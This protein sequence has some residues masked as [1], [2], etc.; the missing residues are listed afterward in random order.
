MNCLTRFPHL[1]VYFL[2][3]FNTSAVAFFVPALVQVVSPISS[4]SP[5]PSL[6]FAIGPHSCS[7]SDEAKIKVPHWSM[8][9]H[10]RQAESAAAVKTARF[11]NKRLPSVNSQKIQNLF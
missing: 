3:L 4:E 10:F 6:R 9:A 1:W 2:L 11:S 5:V 7:N 8:R